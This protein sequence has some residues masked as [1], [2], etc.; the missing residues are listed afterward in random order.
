MNVGRSTLITGVITGVGLLSVGWAWAAAGLLKARGAESHPL[1]FIV[2]VAILL[3]GLI[4]LAYQGRLAIFDLVI[5]LVVAGLLGNVVVWAADRGW[6]DTAIGKAPEV[7][8]PRLELTLPADITEG[9][10]GLNSGAELS[11]KVVARHT[12]ANGEQAVETIAVDATFVGRAPGK[13][14]YSVNIERGTD[15]ALLHSFL[16]ALADAERIVVVAALP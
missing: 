12:K 3:A 16:T 4:V 2:P 11:L 6:L 13:H 1:N 9:A 8:G 14:G 5:G 7:V 10:D 15:D